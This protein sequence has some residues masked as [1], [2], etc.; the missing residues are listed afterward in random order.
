MN[1]SSVPRH[2]TPA[3]CNEAL[4]SFVADVEQLLRVERIAR[5]HAGSDLEAADLLQEAFT[6]ILAGDRAWPCGLD[7]QPFVIEVIRSIASERREKWKRR[8]SH[9]ATTG[10]PPPE[11]VP[12]TAPTAAERLEGLQQDAAMRARALAHFDD[13]P[14]L[15]ALTEALLEGWEKPEMLSLFDHDQ[16]RYNSTR[17][18]LRRR[19]NKLPVAPPQT[20]EPND[21]DHAREADDR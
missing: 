20:G 5:R 16:T 18:R 12:C 11:T 1:K 13:D 15:R 7:A 8:R 2:R 4:E 9:I 6:R 19:L 14:E 10:D 17:R 21:Q 3:E